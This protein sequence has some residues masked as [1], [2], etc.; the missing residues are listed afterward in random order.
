MT[1]KQDQAR[2][3]I[4]LAK[5]ERNRIG[6]L[7]L[8][9]MEFTETRYKLRCAAYEMCVEQAVAAANDA[10]AACEMLK[11]EILTVAAERT[12]HFS[13]SATTSGTLWECNACGYRIED[14]TDDSPLIVYWSRCPCC[15]A[16]IIKE[17]VRT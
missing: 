7:L 15:G 11:T 17:E 16:R 9:L 3:L 8:C 10:V 2:E 13:S 1:E 12:C 5:R 4:H 6:I 14:P